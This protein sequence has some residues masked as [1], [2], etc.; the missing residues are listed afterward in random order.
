MSLYCYPIVHAVIPN[1]SH[2]CRGPCKKVALRS[3]C[4]LSYASSQYCKV[5]QRSC[6]CAFN[7]LPLQHF[8]RLFM[9]FLFSW[10]H[11]TPFPPIINALLQCM[12][13][14]GWW[15]LSCPRNKLTPQEPFL[16]HGPLWVYDL[17]T[18]TMII[19]IY[20]G[21]SISRRKIKIHFR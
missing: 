3:Q 14:H 6:Q 1:N 18:C 20:D 2:V 13:M 19:R 8:N 15:K 9:P 10:W 11:S 16:L 17:M 5:L 12:T 4:L 21:I 7:C